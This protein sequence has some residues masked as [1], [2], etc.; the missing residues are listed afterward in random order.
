[1]KPDVVKWSFYFV[2][3]L[4]NVTGQILVSIGC[5]YLLVYSSDYF[6]MPK[7]LNATS[8][9]FIIMGVSLALLSIMGIVWVYKRNFVL[10]GTF[11]M[12]LIFLAACALIIGVVTLTLGQNGKWSGQL[13][14]DVRNYIKEFDEYAPKLK[15]TISMNRIQSNFKCCGLSSYE[16]WIESRTLNKHVEQELYLNHDFLLDKSQIWFNVPDSCCKDYKLNCGKDFS[17]NYTL[18]T[19]GCFSILNKFMSDFCVNV[20]VICICVI[21]VIFLCVAYF[22]FIGFGFKDSGYYLLDTNLASV[23]KDAYGDNNNKNKVKDSASLK[24]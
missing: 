17:S 4:L 21:F 10:E 24:S 2:N 3:M 20:F 9:L 13:E 16:D 6:F 22:L 14:R 8:S 18:Y 11:I 19:T 5:I 1:M 15:Q 7:L 12:C 23:D